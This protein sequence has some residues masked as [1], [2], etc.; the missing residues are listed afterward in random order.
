MWQFLTSQIAKHI[1]LPEIAAFGTAAVAVGLLVW[2]HLK[3]YWQFW[4]PAILI[5]LNIFA[6]HGW[7]NEHTLLIKEQVAHKADT[8]T[9]AKDQADAN[10]LAQS[11]KKVLLQESKA[12]AD[13]ADAKY[14]TLLASYHA[15]LLRY[16]ASQSG[17][18]ATQ[19]YQLPT[20]Q[21]SDGPSQGSQLPG[22]TTVTIT[23]DD[24]GVCAEN[25]ARLQAVHDWAVDL[26]KQ[27]K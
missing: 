27:E 11:E 14:S 3:A 15:N 19:H 23:L 17:S 24:A 16:K 5:V 21:G 4:V 1:N 2:E 8:A 26:P 18:P 9:F 22:G 7:E 12:N 10:A 6:F 25:T 20:P 13:Q